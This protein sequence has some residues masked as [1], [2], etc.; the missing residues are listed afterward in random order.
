MTFSS[1]QFLSDKVI[2]RV[3]EKRIC[4]PGYPLRVAMGRKR[5]EQVA[6]AGKVNILAADHPARRVTKVGD[7]L[8]AM[9]D[10]RDYLAR[11]LRVLA[12]DKVDGVMA[13]MDVL[14]DLLTID[15]LT[16]EDGGAALLDSKLLVASLNRGGL[17]GSVW[18]LD[19]PITG[20]TPAT[21]MEAGRRQDSSA[22]R[23]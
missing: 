18:E 6:P 8:L 22:H 15:G 19:D 1:T 16:R 20:A 21:C 17:A 3:T 5:R 14:E 2:A 9:T 4:D 11:I 7:Q 10:R 13:T 23:G 12:S